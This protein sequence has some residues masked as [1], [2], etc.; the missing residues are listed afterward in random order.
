MNS[1]VFKGE[2]VVLIDSNFRKFILCIKDK[3][4]K[5]K[6]IVVFNPI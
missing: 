5:F 4:D 1:V 6:G 2:S 3:T